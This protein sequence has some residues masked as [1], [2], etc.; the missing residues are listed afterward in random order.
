M[1]VG[2]GVPGYPPCAGV[3]GAAVVRGAV[4]EGG[5]FSR[6]RML[7][8]KM[9]PWHL[10]SKCSLACSTEWTA[11][12]PLDGI[13]TTAAVQSSLYAKFSRAC[14]TRL[15]NHGPCSTCPPSHMS[16]GL[17]MESLTER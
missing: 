6:V 2:V 12:C 5:R 9:V 13:E 1:T 16:V 15:W 10:F 17:M 3:G 4:V 11:T 8:A 7:G 14:W